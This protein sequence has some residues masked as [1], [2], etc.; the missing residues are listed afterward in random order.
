MLMVIFGAGASYDS[1]PDFPSPQPQQGTGIQSIPSAA[2]TPPNPREIWRPPLTPQ[3]FLDSNGEFGGIVRNYPK[4]LPI[5]PHLR[6]PSSGRSVE[7]EL[8]AW[9]AEASGDPERKR[10]LFSVRYYLHDLLLKVSTEWLKQTSDVTNYVMLLDQIRRLSTGNDPVCLVTFNYDRLLDHALLSFNY[11]TVSLEHCFEAHPTLKLFKPHGSVEWARF[12]DVP[13]DTRLGVE[14]LIDQADSIK[15]SD[16]YLVADASDPRAIHTFGRPIVPAI[17]IPVQTKTEDTFEWPA[18]HRAYLE[19]LLPSVTKILIIGW[20]AKEAHFLQML[21]ERLP[22]HGRRV[23]HI[24]AVG[25]DADDSKAILHR[26]AAEL[27]QSGYNTNH[28]YTSGGFSQFV[29]RREVETFLRA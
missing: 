10:Q 18:H 19:Q 25:K 27:A 12:V 13:Q 17:A 2:A 26:F 5:L 16:E 3:L 24:L 7:E 14:Q 20:Q 4:L 29:A 1:S 28:H 23:A 22:M 11:K 6:R 8:E 15:L 9:Q 21:R